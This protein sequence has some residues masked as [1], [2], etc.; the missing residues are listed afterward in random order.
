MVA[1]SQSAVNS[2]LSNPTA[3]GSDMLEARVASVQLTRDRNNTRDAIKLFIVPSGWIF[4]SDKETVNELKKL[5]KLS[6]QGTKQ[7]SGNEPYTVSYFAHGNRL[8]YVS[9]REGKPAS[10][11]SVGT[12]GEGK[13]SAYSVRGS[14]GDGG[15]VE[16]VIE[17][18][19]N[20]V[21]MD[22]KEGLAVLESVGMPIPITQF[23]W[24][25]IKLE[26]PFMVSFTRQQR[27]LSLISAWE[28]EEAATVS[29]DQAGIEIV[30]PPVTN[31][32]TPAPVALML[33][34]A[35]EQLLAESRRDRALRLLADRT[36]PADELPLIT[37]VPTPAALNDT[38]TAADGVI[39]PREIAVISSAS[40]TAPR[41]DPAAIEIPLAVNAESGAAEPI[42]AT[43]VEDEPGESSFRHSSKRWLE[44]PRGPR[45]QMM[46]ALERF[47]DS[48]IAYSLGEIS[49]GD[50]RGR[51][52]QT[53]ATMTKVKGLVTEARGDLKAV[54][55]ASTNSLSAANREH[56]ARV[57]RSTAVGHENDARLLKFFLKEWLG[58]E[59]DP[60][61]GTYSTQADEPTFSLRGLGS[62]VW[63]SIAMTLP[64]GRRVSRTAKDKAEAVDAL[65]QV[66]R[67]Y[68]IEMEALIRHMDPR[69]K[70]QYR[71]V[72]ARM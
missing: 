8:N 1:N 15:L 24:T 6:R 16:L 39:I 43:A 46:P 48:A 3:F 18:E 28:I 30:L 9:I 69:K 31:G 55:V 36:L 19:R 53:E 59:V 42:P 26:K 50:L 5:F 72:T 49:L 13:V 4:V 17:G 63:L 66:Q 54:A 62:T 44:I 56:R 7:L 57:E 25:P 70:Q 22:L 47:I 64:N 27:Y 33:A 58:M 23:N 38:D 20:V 32:H 10:D 68:D 65:A 67:G 21:K 51:F 12:T 11:N 60:D 52:S 14:A 2:S 29:T 61:C 71:Q 41:L 35:N 40:K 34:T 37:P 45:H